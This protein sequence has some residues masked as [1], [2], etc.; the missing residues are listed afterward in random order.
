MTIQYDDFAKLDLVVGLVESAEPIVGADK[1]LKLTVDVGS[2]KRQ[3]IAGLAPQYK[4]EEMVGKKIVVLTNLEPKKIRG[5]ESQG[6]L[7]AADASEVSL[8]TVDKDV[9]S[10]TKIR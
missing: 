2:E 4:A 5:L 7:L 3:L 1:L 9:P 8:L 6:M 10:G